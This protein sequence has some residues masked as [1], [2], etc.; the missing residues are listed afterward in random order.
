MFKVGEKVKYNVGSKVNPNYYESSVREVYQNG[1]VELN[2]G[3]TFNSEGF[4]YDFSGNSQMTNHDGER[5][6]LERV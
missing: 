5:V 4:H 3:H 1:H 6:K 2:N